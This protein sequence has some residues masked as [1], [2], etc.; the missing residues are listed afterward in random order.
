MK[1]SQRTLTLNYSLSQYTDSVLLLHA[2]Q[3]KESMGVGFVPDLQGLAVSG[4]A[5][6]TPFQSGGAQAPSA[7]PISPPLTSE[8]GFGDYCTV[9]MQATYT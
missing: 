3:L 9:T 2:D 5:Q 8:K 6:P 1:Q 4:G 7:A